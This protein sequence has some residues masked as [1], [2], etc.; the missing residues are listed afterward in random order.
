MTE[1]AK[2]PAP[3]KP[4]KEAAPPA[5]EVRVRKADGNYGTVSTEKDLNTILS[6]GGRTV[7]DKE[8]NNV[9]KETN[10]EAKYGGAGGIAGALEGS[11]APG[12]AGGL[13]G[14]TGG[15][16]DAALIEGAGLLGQG[17]KEATR[18]RLNEYNEFSP[19]GSKGSEIAGI[20]IPAIAA[21]KAPV[22]VSGAV[23]RGGLALEGAVARGLGGTAGRSVLGRLAVKGIATGVQGAAESA[24][25]HIGHNVSE[26]ELGNHEL[27]GQKLV[28]GTPGAALWGFAG[29]AA[30]GGG[31]ELIG[32]AL[33]GAVAA[34]PRTFGAVGEATGLAGRLERAAGKATLEHAGVEAKAITGNE[35]LGRILAEE[36]PTLVGKQNIRG[37]SKELWQEAASKGKQLHTTAQEA[38]L[39]SA[40]KAAKPIDAGEIMADLK[41]SVEHLRSGVGN[42]GS[43]TAI[44]QV[45]AFAANFGKRAGLL[46]EAGAIV[47]NNAPLTLRDV[48]GLQKAAA[49]MG[50]SGGPM[51]GVAESLEQ[52]LAGS[53]EKAGGAEA[54]QAWKDAGTRLK[55][56][57]LLLKAPADGAAGVN[58]L[59]AK[60]SDKISASAGAAIGSVV[61]GGPVG[62]LVGGAAVGLANKLIRPQLS[63]VAADALN[64]AARIAGAKSLAGSVDAEIGRAVTGFLEGSGKVAARTARTVAEQAMPQAAK[65]GKVSR[66]E[67]EHV[68]QRVAN[69]KVQNREGRIDTAQYDKFAAAAPNVAAAIAATH[70][71]GVDFLHASM[72]AARIDT[73]ALTIP[74]SMYVPK[75]LSPQ[76]LKWLR[77]VEAVKDPMGALSDMKRGHITHE[78]VDALKAVYPSLYEHV[79]QTM[80][81]TATKRGKPLSVEQASSL[82]ILL[83][84]PMH[85]TQRP[86]FVAAMQA[87][88]QG[89]TPVNEEG[90][91]A[92]EPRGKPDVESGAAKA[93]TMQEGIES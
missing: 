35:G 56:Y 85:Y 50:A 13:R 45:D 29:G 39:A 41:K 58:A 59:A 40:Q 34:S 71:R 2:M 72:P 27:T 70:M 7:G 22:G 73:N 24:I 33:R 10:L 66:D 14:L 19:I 46:D 57:E 82:G 30:V 63:G 79:K 68:A 1:P 15:L 89:Q 49:E 36:A 4:A 6:Q 75:A 32:S 21:A 51:R 88:K 11:F 61:G 65:A 43:E 62:A 55:A 5:S 26:A 80:I 67:Y 69:L 31:G 93:T 91:P 52:R 17:A 83:G 12:I 38:V 8:W 42:V 3:A 81:E 23:A 20:V 77:S 25:L 28:A 16:S 64:K 47:R 87:S 44:R 86:E 18:E 48:H 9:Q 92:Q 76:E 37:M 74:G 78:Q 53:I 54:I 60:L 90:A 84:Q